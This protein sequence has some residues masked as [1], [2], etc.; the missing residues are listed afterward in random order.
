MTMGSVVGGATTE[1]SAA[2]SVATVG[3]T[4]DKDSAS[5]VGSIA[6]EHAH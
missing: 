6:Q 5:G 1:G 4:P 2:G 3:S